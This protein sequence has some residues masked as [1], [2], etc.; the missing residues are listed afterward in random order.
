MEHLHTINPLLHKAPKEIKKIESTI[1]KYFRPDVK[2]NEIESKLE[3]MFGEKKQVL[4]SKLE[5]TD[6]STASSDNE[7]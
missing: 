2:Q 6:D 4:A 3:A 7:D 1:K 5:M